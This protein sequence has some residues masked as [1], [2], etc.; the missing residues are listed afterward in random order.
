MNDLKAQLADL[1]PIETGKV[2]K[3][4]LPAGSEK[5]HFIIIVIVSGDGNCCSYFYIA[6]KVENAKRVAKNDPESILI[7]NSTDWPILTIES[8][9]QCNKKHLCQTSKSELIKL[10]KEENF[11]IIAEQVP[12]NIKEKILKVS[13]NSKTFTDKDVKDFFKTK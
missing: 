12:Q 9:I 1:L 2:F 6:S 10:C 11:E 7:L 4:K 5:S 3:T 13:A 8:C